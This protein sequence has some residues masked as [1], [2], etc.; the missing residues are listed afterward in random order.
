MESKQLKK[1]ALR[2]NEGEVKGSSLIEFPP[3]MILKPSKS[4]CKIVTP[5]TISSGFLIKF[6]SIEEDFFFLMTNEHII[7]KE[8]IEQKKIISLYYD[9]ESKMKDIKLNP[10]ERLIKEFTEIDIDATV[11]QILSKD[12]IEKDYFL[13]PLIDYINNYDKLLHKEITIIQY[14]LGKHLSYANGKIEKIDKYEFTHKTSTKSGSSGSPV[15]LEDNIKVI[16]IHKCKSKNIPENYGDFIGPIFNYFKN[17]FNYKIILENG[18]YYIG[19]IK[20]KLK[21]GKGK[22]YYSNGNIK[23]DGEFVDDK[24]EGYGKYI[25]ENGRYYIGKWKNNKM[26]GKGKYLISKGYIFSNTLFEGEYLNGIRWNGKGKEYYDNDNDKIKFEGEYLDGKR[27][28]KM[29]DLEYKKI[30]DLDAINGKAKIYFDNGKLGIEVDYPNGEISG[31][32]KEYYNDGTLYFKGE[33][34]NGKRNGKGK[35][36]YHNG[37]I[38]FEGEY[39][40]G[41]RNGRAKEYHLNGEL[42][43][44]GEYLNGK[45]NGNGKEY[46]ISGQLEFEGEYSNGKRWNGKGKEYRY[47]ELKFEGE[48]LNGK[49][50][51]GKVKEYTCGDFLK[52]EGEYLN[53]KRN[54]Y[55]KEYYE[56]GVLKFEGEYLNDHKLK[57]IEYSYSGK[58]IFIGQYLNGLKLKG[59]E[60]YEKKLI[61]KG[62]YLNGKRNGN[63]KEYNISGQLEFEGE[64]LNGKKLEKEKNI[65]IMVK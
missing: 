50:W 51:N 4:I 34:L 49:R 13:L 24:F 20:H 19:E 52:F 65:I 29:Y 7:T 40:N 16:V 48:Y 32:G 42:E 2:I 38:E 46:N 35:A 53:G 9:N 58:L 5:N 60:Y 61:F 57:G 11:V 14:P 30:W 10:E 27:N 63:G 56:R 55:G 3:L 45:R 47:G 15:F 12:N 1:D 37:K 54:G 26:H 18:D 62:D 41:L 43:F 33:Y 39:S 28:G 36:Y 25:E 23:Y 64:Y 44:E 17:G 21:N 8:L 31:K 59:E 22:L 6:F